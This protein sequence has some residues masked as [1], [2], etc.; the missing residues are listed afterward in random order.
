M[1]SLSAELGTKRQ[2]SRHEV[3]DSA[4]SGCDVIQF[5]RLALPSANRNQAGLYLEA[6]V[7]L[8]GNER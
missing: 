1:K 2:P 6:D 8:K 4:L 5:S 7:R 3:H